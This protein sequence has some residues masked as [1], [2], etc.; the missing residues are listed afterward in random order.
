M[1][2]PLLPLLVLLS[3][4]LPGC[5]SSDSSDPIDAAAETGAGSVSD[6]AAGAPSGDS[7][8]PEADDD[9]S[10]TAGPD[11]EQ[12]AEVLGDADTPDASPPA[13][14]VSDAAAA[15]WSWTVP[16]TD[17]PSVCATAPEL[18]F[19]VAELPAESEAALFA[20]VQAEQESLCASVG[21]VDGDG[22]SDLL[23]GDELFF[24]CGDAGFARADMPGL[25]ASWITASAISDLDGDGVAEVILG[26]STGS[27][28][29]RRL[30]DD[31][32]FDADPALAVTAQDAM[33]TGISPLPDRDGDG[34]A[35]LI[36]ATAY[37]WPPLLF[38][39]GFADFDEFDGINKRYNALMFVGG[40]GSLNQIPLE[41]AARD[42]GYAPSYAA[43]LATRHHQGLADVMWIAQMWTDDCLLPIADSGFPE[44]PSL[45]V[46]EYSDYGTRAF[47]M[48][49]T[50][51]YAPNGD[52]IFAVSDVGSPVTGKP[53]SVLWRLDSED[54]VAVEFI[55]DVSLIPPAPNWVCWGNT[56]ADFDLDG[57][58]D[59]AAAHGATGWL[60]LDDAGELEVH[61]HDSN[62]PG[63]VALWLGGAEL[64]H[65]AIDRIPSAVEGTAHFGILTGDLFGN[66]GHGD[67]CK[68]IVLSSTPA[69]PTLDHPEV[70]DQLLYINPIYVLRNTC[71]DAGPRPFVGV[72][73]TTADVGAIV[74]LT[75]SD[76]H[77][78][79]RPVHGMSGLTGTVEPTAVFG[80][81]DGLTAQKLELLR[82][83]GDTVEIPPG[84]GGL[85]GWLSP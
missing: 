35:D 28:H 77:V 13:D 68:D 51:M 59:F 17:K 58:I 9:A 39:G 20:A 43:S 1:K 36:Y 40:D 53:C 83:N 19:S 70:G 75:R 44:G 81:P 56:F 6:T 73:T 79:L 61:T 65:E 48:G 52:V 63:G 15:P 34:A 46:E 74:R 8:Q 24:N 80:L 27:L 4:W 62:R 38:A 12:P 60:E 3:T 49:V 18:L 55:E 26:D 82:P 7:A 45:E 78:D 50:H 71:A 85:V 10:S 21:D 37:A 72:R 16:V 5:L 30:R 31:G 25:E 22:R 42:C 69:A 14:D 84:P 2:Q 33:I 64:W 11:V 76:G 66:D 47:P 54:H 23:I 32:G 67:G 29:V 41:Q 57:W